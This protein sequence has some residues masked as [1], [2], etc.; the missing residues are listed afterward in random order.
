MRPDRRG[1]GSPLAVGGG[2][3]NGHSKNVT[4]DDSSIQTGPKAKRNAGVILVVD[5]DDATREAIRE[6][7]EEEGYQTAQASDGH[8]ALALVRQPGFKPDL[9]LLDLMMPTMDGWQLRARLHADP[10]LATI[11][12]VI[13]TAHAAMLRALVNAEPQTPVLRKPLDLD[14]L[15]EVV[16]TYCA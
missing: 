5:D 15:L 4:L 6:F 13:M 8:Q 10:A 12:I 9:M 11:P 3:Q 2:K 14:R 16:A 1:Y 7:L